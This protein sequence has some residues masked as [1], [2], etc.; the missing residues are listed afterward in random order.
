MIII[1]DLDDTLYNEIE[2]VKSGFKSVAYYLSKKTQYS[3]NFIYLELLK[4]MN[5]NGRGQVFN[6]FVKQFN[7]KS[8]YINKCISNYRLHKPKIQIAYKVKKILYNLRKL[9]YPL[10][11]VTDGNKIVQNNKIVSLGLK[12]YIKKIYITH[13]YGKIYAKPSTYC[14]KLIKK[15]EKVKWNQMI[16]I[17]D[18]PK[19]DFINLKPLGMRTIRILQGDYNKK[20][21]S[22]KF[23]AEFKI[24]S[25]IDLVNILQ[26]L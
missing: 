10:Y 21:V 4:I 17:G 24:F 23:D 11:I 18:N 14:F 22:K 25:L 12:K 19:K 1:F 13:R 9:N 16:Y 5:K 3:Q 26:K 6:I 7:L 15:I 2:F 20:K 8:Y